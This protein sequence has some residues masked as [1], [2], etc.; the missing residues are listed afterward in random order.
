MGKT[1]IEFKGIEFDIEYD[2]Q[3]FEP[4]ETGP[5]AQYPGCEEYVDQVTEFTHKG[6]NFL[7][8]IY[9]GNEAEIDE[10][11]LESRDK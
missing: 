2:Y 10:L 11:I 1:T 8:L 6:T 7:E 9:E 3:P 4:P 5:E